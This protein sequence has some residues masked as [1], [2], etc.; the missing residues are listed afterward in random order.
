MH[1]LPTTHTSWSNWSGSVTCA[2]ILASPAGE[3]ELA[4]LLR[5]TTGT[6][7]VTGSGHSFTPLC[8]AGNLLLALDALQ[9]LIAADPATQQATV[10]AGTKLH[11]LGAPLRAEGLALA[12]MGDI[13]RQSLAGA[14]STGTH[15]TGHTLGNLASQVTALR[16][17]TPAGDIVECSAT[18]EP[19]I[20][21]A[22][23]LSL[24]VLGLITQ[25]T[26]QCVPAYKLYER[27]WVV[28][29]A[30]CMALLPDLI[31][32]N[33]HFEFF[34]SPGEDAC[35]AKSLN[36]T[37]L[38]A[39]PDITPP[40]A[41]GRLQRYVGPARVDW[42]DRIFPSV[43]NLR[44]NE[45]EFSLPAAAGPH[46]MAEIRDLMRT[47]FP[48][49]V[50]PVE[51][52]TVAADPIWLSPHHGRASVTISVHQA[53]ELPYAEF[54]AA[55]EAVFRNH[56][57]RPHWGKLHTHTRRDL[58]ALYPAWDDFLTVRAHLDPQGRMLNPYLRTLFLN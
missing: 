22:A 36:P 23:Q 1:A 5:S 26:L 45:T 32:H 37:G 49:V 57:G 29:Y 2:P 4:H 41:W 30:D 54:F 7:R 35:A 50:W 15:G 42:S 39:P 31:A 38:E 16:L 52:R 40:Y 19:Q 18:V 10:W 6:L 33:R 14:I 46:C 48:D 51:Y 20:F 28:P 9:G 3:A 12:N 43:R 25:I 13:D 55:V 17:L 58:A 47:R 34:W 24:G 44:F 56:G 53:A 27:T 21:H 8:E 11:Q